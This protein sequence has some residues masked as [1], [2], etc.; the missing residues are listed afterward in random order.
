MLPAKI[1]ADKNVAYVA[2]GGEEIE[3]TEYE[4]LRNGTFVWEFATNGTVPEGALEIGM[5][6]DGEKL[7]MARALYGGAQTPGKLVS[8]H[9]CLYLPFGGAEVLVTEYEVLV[10]K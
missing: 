2:F 5:A 3:K 4:V 8:T 9:G 7:Y 6:A 1:L 10:S